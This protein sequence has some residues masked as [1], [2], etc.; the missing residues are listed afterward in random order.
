M[1]EQQSWVSLSDAAKLINVSVNTILRR[2]VDYKEDPDEI[3]LHPCP[4]RKVRRK[5]PEPGEGT[6]QDYDYY[7]PDLLMWLK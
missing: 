6:R 3:H 4:E 2:A 1:K 7:T 5:Q